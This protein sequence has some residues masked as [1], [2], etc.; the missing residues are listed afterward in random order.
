MYETGADFTNTFRKLS[1]LKF[2]SIENIDKDIEESLEII[3]K[4]CS[5]IDE[6]RSFFKPKMPKE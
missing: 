6:I 3:L 2:T 4:Q 5:S 1:L